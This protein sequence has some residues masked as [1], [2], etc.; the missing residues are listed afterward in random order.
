VTPPLETTGI[1]MWLQR[2]LRSGDVVF[3]VGANVGGYAGLAAAAV[4]P[5]GHVYA[6]EP[7]PDNLSELHRLFDRATNVTI[8]A[9]AVSD[10]SGEATLFIDRRDP[11]R[12][13]LAAAN[14][15]KAGGTLSVGQ[16]CL[17]D[18]GA[19]LTRL[20]VIKIDAQGAEL[21]IL[22]GARQAIRR[23][24]PTLILEVWPAGLRNLGATADRLLA[25]VTTLGYDIYRLSSEGVLKDKRHITPI[26]QTTERWKNINV[27][28]LSQATETRHRG[29]H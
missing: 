26:L 2:T 10:R 24:K 6:F 3:D 11:R 25:E 1:G 17:D 23:F 9:A 4:G 16:V 21:T 7:G 5:V 8:V 22:E 27:V 20:D 12:H 29:P 18:Y 28:A 15:G 19:T 14:V 13:S